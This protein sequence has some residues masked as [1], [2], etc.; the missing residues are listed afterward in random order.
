MQIL[1][2]T[3]LT[4]ISI[5]DKHTNNIYIVFNGLNGT[6]QDNGEL[7]V[8]EVIATDF[9]SLCKDTSTIFI[10]DKTMSWGNSVE[11]D[12]VYNI[13][14]PIIEN[15][16]STIVGMSMGGSNA[17]LS[18][19]F[20]KANKMLI[21]NPQFTIHPGVFPDNEW[22]DWADR[23]DTWN[24][25]TV[26]SGFRNKIKTYLLLS[27]GIEQD[28]K[29]INAFP[30]HYKIIKFDEHYTHNIALDLKNQGRLGMLFDAVANDDLNKLDW[31]SEFYFKNLT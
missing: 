1:Y 20:L 26:E 14:N 7:A 17:I 15:K 5:V 28:C 13:V 4:R 19:Q 9:Y 24:F 6:L 29:F 23:I 2:E 30:K 22:I 16:N 25:L 18:S 12:S 10:T 8:S 21:I 3:S 31:L 27:S 11:W